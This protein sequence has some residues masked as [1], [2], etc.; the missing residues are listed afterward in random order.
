MPFKLQAQLLPLSIQHEFLFVIY[1]W[2]IAWMLAA[3]FPPSC[4]MSSINICQGKQN[5]CR[6][7]HCQTE[8]REDQNSC[9][10]ILLR[11]TVFLPIFFHKRN[12]RKKLFSLGISFICPLECICLCVLVFLGC[13]PECFFIP[14]TE[15]FY[16]WF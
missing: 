3:Q 14:A 15:T 6:I 13:L 2:A 8:G 9:G 10:F 1:R 4:T 7:L 16:Y 5:I 11:G 12:I